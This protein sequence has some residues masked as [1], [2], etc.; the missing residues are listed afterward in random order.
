MKYEVVSDELRKKRNDYDNEPVVKELIAGK[1]VKIEDFS[2]NGSLYRHFATKGKKLRT[3]KLSHKET[4]V[5]IENTLDETEVK[6]LTP[7][8]EKVNA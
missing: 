5:W 2:K 4:I 8:K 7:E 6:T 3:R 1:T